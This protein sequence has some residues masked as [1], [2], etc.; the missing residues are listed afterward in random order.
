MGASLLLLIAVVYVIVA[1]EYW[2]KGEYGTC[3]AFS[4]YA[5]S[6]LGFA[7]DLITK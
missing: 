1:S 7:Y 4:A 6:N 2:R 5:V 3:V